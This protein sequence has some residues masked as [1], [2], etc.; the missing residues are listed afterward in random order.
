MSKKKISLRLYGS[1]LW[2]VARRSFAISPSLALLQLVDSIISAAFP[3][4]TTYYA[5]L[6]TTALTEAYAGEAG[7]PE[8]ALMYVLITAGLGVAILTWGSIGFFI[9]TRSRYRIDVAIESEMI[10]QFTGLTFAMYDDKKMVDMHDKA[11]KFSRMFSN[12]FSHLGDMLTNIIKAIGSVIAL[13]SVS[14]L[15]A[16][17]VFFSVIPSVIINV[18]LA[19]AQTEHWETNITNRRRMWEIEWILRRPS[20]MAE[21]RV[22]GVI[23]RLI[24]QYLR[25]RANDEKKRMEM[26]LRAG[27]LQLGANI[28]ESAVELGALLW[29]VLQIIAHSQP[30][31]QFVFVQQMVGRAMGSVRSLATQLGRMDD[32]FAHMIDYQKFMELDIAE[33]SGDEMKETPQT[34]SLQRV[35]FHYPNNKR[36]VLRNINVSIER[37]ARV[38]FV[39]ENGAG[40][41]TLI[42]LLLGLYAPTKGSLLIDGKPLADYSIRSWHRQIG[43]LWQQFVTY[44]HGTIRENIELG[45]VTKKA[46]EQTITAAIK[47]AKFDGVVSK[48]EKGSDTYINKWMGRD[49]DEAS[50]TELSGGQYQRL[51]LAR[52]FYRDA[53]III[54][55]EPTSA[56]DALAETTIF[57]QILSD[58]DKTIITISHRLSMIQKVDVVYMLEDGKIVES[59]SPSELIAKKGKFYTMF[60]SQI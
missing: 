47:K 48:L 38:A 22:Y 51:A 31:G 49:N 57:N 18:R 55:D 5:A 16:L 56:I 30:V 58:K 26:D 37:G 9:S 32:D 21:M 39:G 6:T 7:A 36:P 60:E 11:Q 12:I 54:L 44:D 20:S 24:E 59:G 8:K 50:A 13:L 17:I 46:T 33:D 2:F 1:A 19:R 10:R 43:L 52:S 3:I 14:P 29:V 25:Y 42:K 27:W 53:P 34:I 23:N 4:A 40:K 28:L 45:D 41:S 15:L 35:W